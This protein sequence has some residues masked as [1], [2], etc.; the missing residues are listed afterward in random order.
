M[1]SSHAAKTD[2]HLISGPLSLCVY[3]IS[4][5]QCKHYRMLS[6]L[7]RFTHSS[8]CVINSLNHKENFS[9]FIVCMAM[10]SLF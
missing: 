6:N 4:V 10:V 9:V 2:L 3:V 5:S 8:S 1:N 7:Q